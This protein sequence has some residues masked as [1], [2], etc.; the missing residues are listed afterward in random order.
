MTAAFFGFLVGR[1]VLE[2]M[3]A[4]QLDVAKRTCERR[5]FQ[6]RF[7]LSILVVAR[8]M[9]LR[10]AVTRCGRTQRRRVI[11]LGP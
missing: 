8:L 6:K 3:G 5:L 11:V 7:G 10:D 2:R 9:I 4:A 1:S